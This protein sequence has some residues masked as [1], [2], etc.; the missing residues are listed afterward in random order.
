[1]QAEDDVKRAKREAGADDAALDVVGASKRYGDRLALQGMRFRV[2]PGEVHGLLGPNGAGKTTL[3]RALLGLVA[4]DGGRV[5]LLGRPAGTASASSENGVAGFVDAPRFY[6]YLSGSRNLELLARLDG[7]ASAKT[8]GSDDRV[9]R[10]LGEVGLSEAAQMKVGAY[11]AGMRQRLGLAAALLRAPKLLLLDEP[12]TSLDPAGARDI[13]ALVRRLADAGTAVLL[14]S[15][16]MGEVEDLCEAITI[17]DRGRVLFSGRTEELRKQTPVA[18]HVL[19]TSD[20]GRAAALAATQDGVEV[21]GRGGRGFDVGAD[22]AALDRYVI[23]LGQ[24]GIA[25]RALE[26]RA[27]SLEALFLRLTGDTSNRE[28]SGAE[29][30]AANAASDDPRHEPRTTVRGALAVAS[31][32]IAKLAAQTKVWAALGACVVSPFVF[33][34]VLKLQTTLPEDTLFGRFVQDSGFAVPLCVLGFAASWALPALTCLVAGDLFASEDR[35]C[36]W[37]T[38]LTR[39]RTHDEVFFGKTLAALAYTFTVVSLLAIASLGAGLLFVGAQPL[40]SLSGTLLPPGRALGLDV[41]AWASAFPPAF[42]FAGVAVLASVA[43]RSS[44]AGVGLPVVLGLVM[45]LYALVNGPDA[46]R[47]AMLNAPFG[48]WHGLAADPPF[49]GPLA[50]GAAVS[51][52]YFLVS[53]AIAYTLFGRRDVGS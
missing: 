10:V 5:R 51:V 29:P 28:A 30:G 43:T 22:E 46:V 47:R 18:V 26:S 23:A 41:L 19:S 12:T 39:S 44:V 38:L 33:V 34:V 7:A 53:V 35:Q 52:T 42:A 8:G 4:L 45:E 1:V 50:E 49:H 48:A 9:A 36:T 6:P 31:V 25:V 37:P 16:D 3:L 27:R 2:R 13:R 14:S 21:E 20:D 40:V 24:A 11:S 17:V 32:E 15:H